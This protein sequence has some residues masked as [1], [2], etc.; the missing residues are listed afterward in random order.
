MRF[1]LI[2]L[3]GAGASAALAQPVASEFEKKAP[4]QTSTAAKKLLARPQLKTGKA[5]TDDDS[6]RPM[7]KRALPR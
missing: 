5:G 3:A 7:T 1:M 2:I 6:V 4:V